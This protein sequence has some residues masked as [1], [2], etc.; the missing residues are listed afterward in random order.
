MQTDIAFL[1]GRAPKAMTDESL[2]DDVALIVPWCLAIENLAR[3]TNCCVPGQA[4]AASY[5]HGVGMPAA[6]G[7]SE[8]NKSPKLS[9]QARPAVSASRWV[10]PRAHL[11]NPG[12]PVQ[13]AD[14][15]IESGR[16]A[17][18]HPPGTPVAPGFETLHHCAGR[19]VMPGLID[20][21][22]HLPAD[23]V[24]KLAP[25]FMRMLVAHGVTGIRE[26]GDVDGTA[27][28]AVRAWQQHPGS[29]VPRIA[30]AHYFVGR[31]PFRWKNSLSYRSPG[32]APRIV[33]RLTNVGAQCIKL[34]EN[35]R[36]DDIQVLQRHAE[37]AGLVVMGHVPTALSLEAA[38]IRDTQHFFGVPPPASLRRDHVFCRTADWHAVDVERLEA[39][40]KFC[41]RNDIANT[42]TLSI[43]RGL[44]GYRNLYAAQAQLNGR[45]PSF[46][47]D[48]I[49]H[50]SHGLPAYRGL[51][52]LDFDA[53]EDAFDKKKLLVRELFARGCRL[54]PGTDTLQ[55]F[56]LPGWGLQQELSLFVDAGL[57]PT[58]A[59]KTATVDAAAALGWADT[60]RVDVGCRADLVVLSHDPTVSL[61]ALDSIEQV[62]VH[63]VPHSTATLHAEIEDDLRARESAFQR[64]ASRVLAR[65]AMRKAA[66]HFT[67]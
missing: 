4:G 36:A 13:V 23:N 32:D 25:H 47:G 3:L 11:I 46:F 30:S 24:L 53:L 62:I 39:V 52:S 18:L 29:V 45:M 1:R 59:L 28:R 22:A 5:F 55:P 51:Q 26:A 48:V 33:E 40:A 27:M 64:I 41:E 14:V 21:H 15:W 31:P 63:G 57:T 34:Y 54:F 6:F 56:C 61:S 66:R 17:A 19:W 49:W 9:L 65:L 38:G 16:I 12:R 37:Q 44:L 20:M 7:S 58:Q 42:P 2:S 35:L 43:N 60:G 50:P 8:S 67:G 10:L